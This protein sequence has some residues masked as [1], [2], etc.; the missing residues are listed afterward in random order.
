MDVEVDVAV[1]SGL[2]VGSEFCEAGLP[3]APL[4]QRTDE[5]SELYA[6][7]FLAL[8]EAS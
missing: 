5:S 2:P 8:L 7:N 4:A 6:G 1:K 3:E